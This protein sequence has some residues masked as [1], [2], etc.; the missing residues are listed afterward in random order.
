MNFVLF[1]R[2]FSRKKWGGSFSYSERPKENCNRVRA[3]L[4]LK[5]FNLTGLTNYLKKFI[6][7]LGLRLCLD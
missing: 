1:W 7:R 6:Y 5:I 4:S 3:V 2:K